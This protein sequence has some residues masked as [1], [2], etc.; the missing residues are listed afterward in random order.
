VSHA[1]GLD[2][3]FLDSWF[4][5]RAR[6]S[7]SAVAMAGLAD[8]L[9][10]IGH[11]VT[12]LRAPPRLPTTDFTRLIANLGYGRRT[13]DLRP[14]LVVGFDLDG[15]CHR[16]AGCPYVVALKG[17]AADEM[18][19]ER[20][21]TRLR[22][23]LL[24]RLERRNARRADRVI[25]TSEYSRRAAIEAYGLRPE[26]VAVV[27]EG[28]DVETWRRAAPPRSAG[29]PVI[30]S[31]AR[32]YPRKNTSSLIRAMPRV[33][34][35]VPGV[36]L[37]VIG[38]GPERRRL[39]GLVAR[40]GLEETVDL[41]GSLPGAEAVRE[42]LA[43]ATVFCLPSR[44]EG[45]GIV[46]LEAMAA[47]LAIVAADRGAVPEVA[48]HGEVA[49]LVDPDDVDGLADALIRLLREPDLRRRLVAGGTKRWQRYDW[50]HVARL[51]LAEVGR[52]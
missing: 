49:L 19:F 23:R 9:R 31:V 33:V 48:P 36:R 26:D 34:D 20:G 2:I 16:R 4:T 42:E 1:D 15:F 29:P 47:G 37:R 51:F 3:V 28:I 5:D 50:T 44:Q 52:R 14:D 10:Q 8:G 38:D 39:A 25:T 13:R 22:F 7:G 43:R 6:G 45:F 40:L 11:R 24:A 27:P 30:A 32:Q 17:V 21:W 12:V 35:A 46:F 41:P 18:R